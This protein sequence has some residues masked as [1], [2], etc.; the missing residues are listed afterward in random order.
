MQGWA[1]DQDSP[2]RDVTVL[3]DG[4]PVALAGLTWPRPDVAEGF[5]DPRMGLCGF[6]LMVSLLPQLRTPGAHS[7]AVEARLL[8]GRSGRSSSVTVLA[9]RHARPA[10]GRHGSAR[11]P[12][13]ARGR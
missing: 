11:V 4:V 5:G 6:D 12:R 10:R 1:H 8:D 13:S 2:V 9:G 3:V 7:V